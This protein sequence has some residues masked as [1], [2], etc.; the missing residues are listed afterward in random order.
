MLW[1]LRAQL[2]VVYVFAGLAKLNPDW[3]LR[4]QPLRIWLAAQRDFPLLGAWLSE[5]W[6]AYL[7][8][9]L[10]AAFDLSIVGFLLWS[11][12]RAYAYAA[13]VVFHLCTGLWFPIGMFPWIMIL[14]ATLFFSPDWPRRLLPVASSVE[15]HTARAIHAGCAGCSP[16]TSRF[17]WRSRSI[18]TRVTS[19]RPGPVV[20]STSPGR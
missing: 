9:W 11:R 17:K 2:G 16:G 4:A 6:A 8:S 1:T 3:L 18:N 5:V 13:L 15:A 19:T 12:T 10:G 20:A 7:L 14:S